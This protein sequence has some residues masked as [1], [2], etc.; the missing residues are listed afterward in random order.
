MDIDARIFESKELID[1][2]IGIH[3]MNESLGYAT[4]YDDDNDHAM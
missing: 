3:V 1:E 2:G 4:Q